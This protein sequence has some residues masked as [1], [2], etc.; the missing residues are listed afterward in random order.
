[1][2]S[3]LLRVLLPAGTYLGSVYLLLVVVEKFSQ[4]TIWFK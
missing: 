3:D 2:I 4:K 1:M